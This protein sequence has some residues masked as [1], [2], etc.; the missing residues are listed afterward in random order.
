MPLDF[1]CSHCG[2]GVS[3]PEAQSGHVVICPWCKKSLS[4]P[5]LVMAPPAESAEPF[6]QLHE[7]RPSRPIQRSNWL[8]VLV[9]FGVIALVGAGIV[10]VVFQNVS[11]RAD[12]ERIS[13]LR[14][15]AVR[16][17]LQLQSMQVRT[18]LPARAG[19]FVSHAEMPGSD[20]SDKLKE[21]WRV[22][23]EHNG[24]LDRHPTWVTPRLNDVIT[25]TRL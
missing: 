18:G 9:S 24:I 15:E 23:I 7:R 12:R 17:K 21:L 19:G 22:M 25:D 10:V 5:P 14:T 8:I 4:V 1:T 2:G 16:L 6:R 3:V 11:E 13:E 20:Y